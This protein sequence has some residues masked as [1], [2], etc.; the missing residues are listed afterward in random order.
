MALRTSAREFR[1]RSSLHPHHP[2]RQDVGEALARGALLVEDAGGGRRRHDPQGPLQVGEPVRRVRIGRAHLLHGSAKVAPPSSITRTRSARPRWPD[3]P[4]EPRRQRLR[5]SSTP[6]SRP[7]A[8][9]TTL[10]A[11][12]GGPFGSS[13]RA[14]APR[15]R[16]ER[17]GASSESVTRGRAQRVGAHAIRPLAVDQPRRAVH[18]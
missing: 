6:T 3:G 17:C 5:W 2:V 8:S 7:A 18:G 12:P 15:A 1:D 16:S 4:T 14:Q 11:S 10:G 13:V 9:N